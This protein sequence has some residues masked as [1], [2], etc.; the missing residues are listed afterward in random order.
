VN[1]E[2]DITA[3]TEKLSTLIGQLQLRIAILETCVEELTREVAKHGGS[4]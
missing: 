2:V 1:R 3:V 4:D